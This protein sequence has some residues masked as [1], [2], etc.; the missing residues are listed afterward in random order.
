MLEE[1]ELAE[2]PHRWVIARVA[3]AEAGTGALGRVRRLLRGP[4]RLR[5]PGAVLFAP[6]D[7]RS[8][9]PAI[10]GEMAEGLFVLG[11]RSVALRSGSPFEVEPPSEA[12]REE[13]HGFGWLRHL[14]ASGAPAAQE[15]AGRLVRAAASRG[16]QL[17]A[18]APGRTAV[19]A[20]RLRSLLSHAP[21]VL[22]D[23]ER[24]LY[25]DYLGLIGL[26]AH[27]LGLDM[28]EAPKPL[29]R[30]AAAM[31]VCCAALCSRG[32][33]PRF[34]PANRALAA[35]LDAQVLADGGHVSRNPA[36]LLE[37]LLD[38]LP[39]RPLYAAREM[40]PPIAFE[41]AVERML[42]MLRF[43]RHGSGELALFN[44]M[45]RTPSDDLATVLSLDSLRGAPVSRAEPSGYDRLEA[46]TTLVL[47]DTG[48][49]PALES[50]A[51]AHAGSLAFELSSGPNRLVVNCGAPACPGALREAARLTAAHSTLGVGDVPSATLLEPGRGRASAYLLRRL[52]RV[53]LDGP[54]VTSER[55]TGPSGALL[56]RASHDG[57]RAAFGAVHTRLLD[58]TADGAR[59]A[60]EDSLTIERQEGARDA[61]A[62]LRFHLHPSAQVVSDEAG[63]VITIELPGG[64]RWLFSCN[65]PPA[66][67]E[68]SVFFAVSEGR[69][70]SKQIV[71]DLPVAAGFGRASVTW[72]FQRYE[73]ERPL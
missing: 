65:R 27:Q 60:G 12:W 57:Y 28:H 19:G 41:E 33:E 54:D 35:E 1:G 59:L 56:L 8:A 47:V 63:Q 18:E 52:G 3:L 23:A 15:T 49:P 34:R 21:F 53:V 73:P 72:L 51:E 70:P 58:L 11:G 50:S 67:I 68:D 14:H 13:L 55:G 66:R 29:D 48:R 26:D 61:P 25:R 20:R 43:F 38:L 69:R 62:R 4:R 24:G 45:G 36:A 71:V 22:A 9:D 44:G 10:A 31:A 16:R 6:Q 2:A 40:E 30:L 17:H 7:L 46:G 64:E 32:L 5:I 37:L 39:L 42:P